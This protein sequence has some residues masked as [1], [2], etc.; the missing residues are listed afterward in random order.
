[1]EN[2]L[3]LIDF[4]WL[5]SSLGIKSFMEKI[6]VE[7]DWMERRE[8]GRGELKKLNLGQMSGDRSQTSMVLFFIVFLNY[9][10]CTYSYY[11]YGF[12]DQLTDGSAYSGM[13][14]SSDRVTLRQ[15]KDWSGS[16]K[17]IKNNTILRAWSSFIL[18]EGT[19]AIHCTTGTAPLQVIQFILSYIFP[20]FFPLISFL[21]FKRRVMIVTKVWWV[22][23]DHQVD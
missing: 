18:T 12:M 4:W 16:R 23:I 14:T 8:W 20:L 22:L 17:K 3:Q 10:L 21:Y 15:L 1:M 7:E 19:R 9:F 2:P 6:A 5:M 11:G 13:V